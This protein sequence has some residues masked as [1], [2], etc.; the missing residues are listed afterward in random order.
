MKKNII[1]SGFS[2]ERGYIIDYLSEKHDWK[3][4]F[5]FS[6]ERLCEWVKKY[7]PDA[8]FQESMAI[9]QARFDFFD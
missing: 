6:A 4:V 1:Y 3:P 5:F 9:R 8:I 2:D 7:Y